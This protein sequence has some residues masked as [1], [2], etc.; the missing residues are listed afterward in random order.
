MSKETRI[1]IIVPS[2]LAKDLES[3][4]IAGNVL[5][6]DLITALLSEC[7]RVMIKSNDDESNSKEVSVVSG[8]SGSMLSNKSGSG[9]G[10]SIS[11]DKATERLSE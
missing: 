10:E 11:N 8:N 4:A 1:T 6:N 2:K 7:S 3:F 9:L 5:L